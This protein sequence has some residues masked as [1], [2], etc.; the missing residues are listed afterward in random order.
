[1]QELIKFAMMHGGLRHIDILDSVI[2]DVLYSGPDV[3]QGFTEE[4]VEAIASLYIQVKL[5]AWLEY[6]SAVIISNCTSFFHISSPQ[7]CS[8]L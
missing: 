4:D 1:M 2:A 5:S 8:C 6:T 7:A 3:L